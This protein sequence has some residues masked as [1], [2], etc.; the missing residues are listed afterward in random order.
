[1]ARA[2]DFLPFDVA[3]LHAAEAKTQAEAAGFDRPFAWVGFAVEMALRDAINRGG[4]V[5]AELPMHTRWDLTLG[6]PGV[7]QPLRVEVKTRVA[8]A[9]WTDPAMFR[10]IAVPTH[11]GRDPIKP[12]VDVAIFCWWSADAPDVAWALGRLLGAAEFRERATFYREGEPTPREAE[13]PKGGSYV[14][15][16]DDLRPL[17][18]F[19]LARAQGME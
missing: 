3:P 10:W 13:A 15:S 9:G 12:E 19:L 16:V 5:T 1:M 14:L 2:G 18:R 7:A 17:P 4:A 11:D 6:P 8:A